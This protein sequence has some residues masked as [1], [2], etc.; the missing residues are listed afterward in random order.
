MPNRSEISP[1]VIFNSVI[2]FIIKVLYAVNVICFI[3]MKRALY[4][5]LHY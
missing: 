2:L 3:F 4:L 5:T 1:N